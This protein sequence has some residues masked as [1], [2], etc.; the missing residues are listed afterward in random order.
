[1][2]A[3]SIVVSGTSAETPPADTSGSADL[4]S[5]VSTG[6]IVV[7]TPVGSGTGAGVSKDTKTSVPTSIKPVSGAS[8]SGAQ[9]T[10]QV[11][12]QNDPNALDV[13]FDITLAVGNKSLPSSGHVQ[14]FGIPLSV[15]SQAS[16]FNNKR[17]QLYAGYGQG[18]P[19]ANE[20]A[21]HY[22]LILDGWIR[23]CFGNWILNNLSVN[24]V[25]Q[26]S[27]TTGGSKGGL[28][29]PTDV[30]N[31][32]HNMPS[33][34]PLSTAIK[35]ALSVAF[36]G[37]SLNINISPKLV[38]NYPDWG[39]HQ[40]L[41]QYGNYLKA[42]SH[43]ILGT[44]N[45]S[46]YAGVAVAVQGN[47]IKVHDG[48]VKGSAIA[49]KYEDLIGQPT[50]IDLNTVQ[51]T[52][53]LRGDISPTGSGGTTQITL[54]QTLTTM[55]EQ[56]ASASLANG[57]F[58]GLNGNLLT[59]QGTWD[60]QSVRHIGRFRDPDWSAWC[61][62]IE[63]IQSNSSSGAGGVAAPTTVESTGGQQTFA[64]TG[65]GSGTGSST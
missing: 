35:N 44:P 9:W 15:V 17:L 42:L 60:V 33:G 13:A 24:F 6:D 47:N 64:Q 2:R 31:I 50:W 25:V 52:T 16:D 23:P 55:T 59:F 49:I 45:T 37:A 10:S 8:Q 41:E 34:T 7:D 27:S 1:M 53:V 14:V 19:L 61:S 62:I 65:E 39:F 38:L 58:T 32:V 29:G 11:G 40:S 54:P 4:S 43:S 26:P 20:Q 48:T 12:G 63:A 30:K 46:G 21:P 57:G 51:V 36:P 56:G 18:L 5:T 3:Y 22:G 28:G